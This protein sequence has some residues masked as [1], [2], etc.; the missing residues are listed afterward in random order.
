[1]IAVLAGLAIG[2][3]GAYGVSVRLSGQLVEVAA[4]DPWLFTS[5]PLLLAAVAMFA[6]W[7]PAQRAA[8]VDPMVALRC[9]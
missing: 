3:A 2:T 6:C 4:G 7:L 8:R 9:E 1:M 5:L